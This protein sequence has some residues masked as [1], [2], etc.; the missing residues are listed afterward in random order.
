M[1]ELDPAVTQE[2]PYMAQF[3]LGPSAVDALRVWPQVQ[4][5]G[6]F[7][8]AHHPSLVCTQAAV[9]RRE[10][11]LVGHMLDP[12][13][14]AASN[15]EIL[16]QLL[17]RF[18]NRTSLLKATNGLGGRWLLIAADGSERFLFHDALG[19]R[20]MFYTDPHR[21]GAVW[22]MSQPGM[23]AD[24]LGLSLDPAASAFM[25]SYA[26][27]AH[28]EY[29]WPGE[30]APFKGL[31]HLLPNHWLDLDTGATYRYWPAGD[32]SEISLDTALDRLA[33][34]L[35]G[36]VEAAA[37]R[38]DLALGLTAGIDSRLALAAARSVKDRISYMSVRQQQMANDH[39]D[40]TIPARLLGQF[41]L[42]HEIVSAQVS[43]TPQ[44]SQIFKQSVYLAHDQY[45]P[46]AEAILKHFR[47][48]KAVLTGSGA[49]VGRCSFRKELPWSDWR[50]ITPAHLARLQCMN[51]ETYALRYFEDWLRD[52][53][54]RH[55]VKL[56]DLFEWEQGH[57]NWLAMTQ[58]EFN[59]AWRENLTLYNCREI[60]TIMLSVNEKYRRS[61][62]N[63]LFINLINRL[64]PELLNE[65]INPHNRG[66]MVGRIKRKYKSLS[67]YWS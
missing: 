40:V 29:R 10:L 54:P 20:Q 18:E 8:L 7:T 44:F 58:L 42:T 9:G 41:G 3:M 26:F 24:L 5:A 4:V 59:I 11:T 55:N 14:P 27:R 67:R 56:L 43:M 46:D 21:V 48:R 19:L 28:S 47:R 2:P 61:S 25:E 23:G 51:G 53:Q 62:E 60:L 63:K 33:C 35:P 32:I 66:K 37:I 31:K 64:W 30:A 45:G 1:G 38:F 15:E 12:C 6:T 39:P 16:R 22:T 52:A 57:G 13:A 36:M 17:S 49:E 34:L 65:P 50:T